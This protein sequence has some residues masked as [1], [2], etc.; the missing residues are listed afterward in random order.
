MSTVI[1][2]SVRIA[3]WDDPGFVHAFEAARDR[4][5][6]AGPTM[7]GPAAAARAEAILHTSGYPDARIECLRTGEEA[8]VHGARWVVR[9]NGRR[10]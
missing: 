8:M 6:E 9:R 4:V 3:E 1:E 5:H 10:G 7:N 2:L